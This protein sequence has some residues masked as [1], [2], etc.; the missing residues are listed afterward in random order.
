MFRVFPIRAGVKVPA[1]WLVE[2][3]GFHKGLQRGGAG[4]SE[5]HAL[6]LV[7]RGGTT[8]EVLALAGEIREGVELTFGIRWSGSRCWWRVGDERGGCSA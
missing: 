7:N 3:S 5:R 2:Q 8:R 6:A 1:A 4:I